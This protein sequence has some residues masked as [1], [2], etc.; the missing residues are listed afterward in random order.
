[1]C[2]FRPGG[3]RGMMLKRGLTRR[4][5]RKN[6]KRS[7]QSLTRVEHK[8][9]EMV[10]Q[11]KNCA[12]PMCWFR[13]TGKRREM[14]SQRQK[15]LFVKRMALKRILKGMKDKHKREQ[16]GETKTGCSSPMCWFRAGREMDNNNDKIL[17]HDNEATMKRGY[18]E[19]QRRR[20]PGEAAAKQIRMMEDAAERMQKKFVEEGKLFG[21]R[22]ANTFG[23]RGDKLLEAGEANVFRDEDENDHLELSAA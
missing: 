8:R 20:D 5:R 22:D 18:N 9:E 14:M 11:K 16:E 17:Q 10:K 19:K 7:P 15:G 1:M 21:S 3:K 13:A 4:E 23:A 6:H 2:W 12:S